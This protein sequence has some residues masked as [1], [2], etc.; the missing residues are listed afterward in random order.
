MDFKLKPEQLLTGKQFNQLNIPVYKLLNK[1]HIQYNGF[2]YSEGLNLLNEEWNPA[3]NG[4][5]GGLYCTNKYETWMYKYDKIAKVEIPDDAEIWTMDE[6]KIKVTKM[7]LGKI[8][9]YEEF[10]KDWDS[11]LEKEYSVYFKI[12]KHKLTIDLTNKYKKLY[13]DKIKWLN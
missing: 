11:L 7:I 10:V 12:P 4:R 2:K 9:T 13:P 6:D 5:G 3:G 8:Q 1:N